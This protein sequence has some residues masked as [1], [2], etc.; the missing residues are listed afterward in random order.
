MRF[1]DRLGLA[2]PYDNIVRMKPRWRRILAALVGLWRRL[3]TFLRRGNM[4]R[5]QRYVS[6]ELSH[7]VGRGRAP[8]ERYALL[9]HI[10]KS[11]WLT[12]P[13][14]NPNISGNLNVNASARLSTN[15]MY[16][17]QIVCFCDIP[18]EDLHIHTSKYSRFGFSLAKDFVAQQG[19]APVQYVPR[20]GR[21][22]GLFNSVTFADVFDR[23]LPEYH[24]LMDQFRKAIMENRKTPGV[25]VDFMRLQELLMFLDF[26]LLSYLKFFDH[27]LP[28]DDPA[29]FYMEREWRVVG[30]IGFA[31][32]DVRRIFVPSEQ[33][34]R[35]R[36]DLPDFSGEITFV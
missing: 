36:S 29:N 20:S 28:D 33:G 19:G 10:L 1:A 30:N 21:P 6:D 13:P 25:P 22:E 32:Q 7:F 2:D 27:S 23:M 4:P 15:D 34:K 5:I 16:S 31:L 8:D 9:I 24:A 35:L 14:H 12:H 11:G 26:R 18:A 3:L 17:P